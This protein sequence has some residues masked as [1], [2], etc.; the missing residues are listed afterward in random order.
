MIHVIATIE[1]VHGQRDRFL[2]EFRRIV[3]QVLEE[4]GCLDYGPAIDLPTGIAAQVPIRS[5]VV[6]IVERWES[7]KHLNAH[8]VAAHMTA[9]RER[10]KEL[11]QKTTLQILEPA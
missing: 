10:V 4:E 9:Y 11:V 1:L 8:L 6:T 5:D 3:P 2:E 7:L